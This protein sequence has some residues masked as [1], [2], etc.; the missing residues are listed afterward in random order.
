MNNR[1]FGKLGEDMDAGYLKKQGCEILR[2]NYRCGEGE[3]DIIAAKDG[4]LRVVE[5]KTR[6]SRFFGSPA[7]AV[8]SRKQ[9]HIRRAVLAYLSESDTYYPTVSMDVIEV[10]INHIK[11]AF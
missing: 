1:E 11:D 8:D 2:R 7:E 6:G 10:V 9:E 4:V 5:V 3:I